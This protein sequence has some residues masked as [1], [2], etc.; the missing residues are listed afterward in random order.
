M[1][2]WNYR[3]L[4][5]EFVVADGVEPCYSI[6]RCY[7]ATPDDPLPTKYA[8]Q[9]ASPEGETIEELKDDLSRFLGAFDKPVLTTDSRGKVKAY[10]EKK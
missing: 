1:V 2:T 4:R 3:V 9:P 8:A 7:Y 5:A 6:H 10:R